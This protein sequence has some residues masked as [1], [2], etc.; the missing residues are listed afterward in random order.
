ML[1]V[2]KNREADCAPS[3]EPIAL[4]TWRISQ[5]ENLVRPLVEEFHRRSGMLQAMKLIGSF[6]AGCGTVA[7]FFIDYLKHLL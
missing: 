1:H 4:L 5:L 6:L 7:A 3:E 2:K